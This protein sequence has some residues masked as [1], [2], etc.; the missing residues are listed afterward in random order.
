M[1]KVVI[2][3][4]LHKDGMAV[5]NAANLETAVS[6]SGEPKE[7]LPFVK[8]ADGLIIRIGHIDKDTMEACPNLK[9]IGR[10]GVGVDNVDVKAA[11][12]L[13]IPVVIAPGAN[14]RSVAEC[15]F[16]MMFAA[17][18]D[19]VRADKELRKGNWAMRS[20]YKAYEIFGKTLGL[21]GY[22]HIGGILAELCKAV[23]MSIM[24]YDPF[25]KKEA[26]EEKGYTYCQTIEPILANAD[27]ISVHVPLT[28]KTRNLIAKDELAKMKKTAILINCARGGI[29]NEQDLYD[30]LKNNVIQC[31]AL[32]VF[33]NIAAD[34]YKLSP[35]RPERHHT[36]RPSVHIPASRWHSSGHSLS[37]R[38]WLWSA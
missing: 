27:V 18:K 11:T 8:D 5:L 38:R 30:A 12:E 36:D 25:V 24:V 32:D 15:A 34:G 31:A 4:P 10:P 9:A 29:I 7:Y 33:D 35:S 17:A 2:T 3:Q 20:E 37:G 14:T 21:I 22:G 13:G 19:M 6:N 23:G 1:S 26:V 28:D 16:A